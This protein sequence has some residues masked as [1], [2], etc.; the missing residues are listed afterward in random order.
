[1]LFKEDGIDLGNYAAELQDQGTASDMNGFIKGITDLN[2]RNSVFV[3]NTANKE[4]TDF[5]AACL[6]QSIAVVACNKIACRNVSTSPS[7][8]SSSEV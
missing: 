1:M 8:V 6:E 7:F 5:Y 2:L 4:V 3:D